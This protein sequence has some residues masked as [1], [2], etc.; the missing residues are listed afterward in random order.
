M[1]RNNLSGFHA[2]FRC[3]RSM[4]RQNRDSCM[5]LT[6]PCCTLQSGAISHPP[7]HGWQHHHPRTQRHNI[8]SGATGPGGSPWGGGAGAGASAG[9]ALARM[10]ERHGIHTPR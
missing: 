9:R 4:T 3:C 8:Q 7:D 10:Y 1:A 5:Q 2:W 6:V